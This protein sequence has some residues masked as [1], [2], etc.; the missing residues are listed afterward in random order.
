MVQQ[1]LHQQLQGR[2]EA[3]RGGFAVRPGPFDCPGNCFER[4]SHSGVGGDQSKCQ[5]RACACADLFYGTFDVQ[6][7]TSAMI[8]LI[9]QAPEFRITSVLITE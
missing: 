8:E 6:H 2:A 9:R 4:S 5:S 7:A 1:V 3:A